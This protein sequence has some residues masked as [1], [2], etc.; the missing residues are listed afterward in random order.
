MNNLTILS[1]NII[2]LINNAKDNMFK[3]VNEELIMLY[4]NVGEYLSKESKSSNWGD[5]FID[6]VAKNIA[7]NFPNLK[8]FNRRGLYRMKQFYE[9]YCD[10]QFVTPLVTQLSW[11]NHLLIMSTCKSD[12]EREFYIKLSIKDRYSKRELARQLDSAYFERYMLSK[13]KVVPEMVSKQI[14]NQFLDRYVLEFLDLPESFSERDLQKSIIKNLKNFVLEFGKDFTFIGEEYKVE[15][16]GSD[17]FIDLLFYHRE[18]VCLVAFELKLGKFK[19]E[20]IGKMNFYL[21]ALDRE[22]KKE[23][24]NPS[25]GIILCSSKDNEVV[26]F[27]LSRNISPTLI[28][29]YQ[30]KLIDKELLRQKL[31]E[32][33]SISDYIDEE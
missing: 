4:Y 12:E 3:K 6:D 21:E 30:T 29:E 20:Y 22:H 8:G 11:T 19:P 15:V 1:D 10:N 16:G 24:E 27:A 25:V 28:A 7:I 26:E 33:T 32:L 23:N 31:H 5:G 17:F 18:L 13:N 9:T 14:S 2:T